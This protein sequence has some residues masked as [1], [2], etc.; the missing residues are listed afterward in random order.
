MAA[1]AATE[2]ASELLGRMHALMHELAAQVSGR[3]GAELSSQVRDGLETHCAAPLGVLA[4]T[5]ARLADELGVAQRAAAEHARTAG[6]QATELKVGLAVT[7]Q[8]LASLRSE[9]AHWQRLHAAEATRARQ[10][11]AE[12][13]AARAALSPHGAPHTPPPS[14]PPGGAPGGER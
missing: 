8:Q 3:V 5:N 12:L 14:A 4:Q 11:E 6:E 9:C 2:V 7:Q 1:A 10:L 13:H